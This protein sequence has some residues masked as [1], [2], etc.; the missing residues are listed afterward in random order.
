MVAI[1]PRNRRLRRT[2]LA[3]IFSGAYSS[4]T[5]LPTAPSFDLDGATVGGFDLSAGMNFDAMKQWVH[6][7]I[8]DA[9]Q[10]TPFCSWRLVSN[11]VRNFYCITTT[12]HR[13][14]NVL[15]C[16]AWSV[17]LPNCAPFPVMTFLVEE[18]NA[19]H[20]DWWASPSLAPRTTAVPP[21]Q[22]A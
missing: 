3:L 10:S 19:W 17:N 12:P 9:Y 6:Q 5:N 2:L 7:Y 13:V 8:I 22:R 16:F 21:R 14:A 4:S 1:K 20:T 11:T 15:R 18:P